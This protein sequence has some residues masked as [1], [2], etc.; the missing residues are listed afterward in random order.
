LDGIFKHTYTKG[1]RYAA[2]K[3]TCASTLTVI[4]GESAPTFTAQ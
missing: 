3:E 4:K 1:M 2:Q